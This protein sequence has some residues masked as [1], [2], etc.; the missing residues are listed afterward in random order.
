MWPTITPTGACAV[1]VRYGIRSWFL[2]SSIDGVDALPV[3]VSPDPAPWPGK[4]LSTGSTPASRRPR[5]Y[6]PA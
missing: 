6:A 5:A 3:W 1:R 2:S 4:C